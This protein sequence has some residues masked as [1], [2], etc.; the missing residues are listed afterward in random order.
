MKPRRTHHRPGRPP[1]KPGGGQGVR[2]KAWWPWLKRGA[3]AVFFV[4]VA[5]LLVSRARTIDW[6]EVFLSLQQYP[7]T[8]VWGAV[9]LAATSLLLYSCFDLLG[10]R[11]T[12][13]TLSA[14]TVMTITFISYAFNLN[15]GSLVGGVA[16]RYRLYSRLG[17]RTGVIARIMSL[18]MLA[19]WMG[20]VALAGLV[21]SLQPLR[22]PASWP[23]DSMHLRLIG[24]ALLAAAA[25][26]LGV[27]AFS[28]QRTLQ[29][30]GHT[31]DLP[32]FRMAG[33]QLL[34]GAANWLLMAGI[35]F[36][37]LQ[38][39]IA[40]SAVL[41]ALLLAAVAGVITRIPAGL[42]VLEAVFVA[43]FSQ[44]MPPHELL[45]ALVAYRLVYF[46]APL[47][48]ASL[49]YLV[50]EAKARQR[51]QAADNRDKTEFSR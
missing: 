29:V 39:R 28:R 50:M 12:G 2:S 1:R 46:I 41:S 27:C 22:L 44:Q 37:L 26:Y 30:R 34:M 5:S 47:G 25:A 15:L 7:R 38:Q 16:F 6:G 10:R 36:M 11:Y 17:L 14:P 45:A 43:L 42:G 32:T 24:V 31:I 19:N 21:F 18:S 8:A 35:V 9:A 33:L 20:Y 49:V 13:H 3:A 48:V 4:L 23:L 51:G 40:F